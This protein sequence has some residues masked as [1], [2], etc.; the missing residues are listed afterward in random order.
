M[1]SKIRVITEEFT[2]GLNRRSFLKR[3][4]AVLFGAVS[5]IALGAPW[6][7]SVAYAISCDNYSVYNY[8]NFIAGYCSGCSGSTCPGGTP[9]NCG[10]WANGC[11]CTQTS[12]QLGNTVYF[13]C[14]D[15]KVGTACCGCAQ[16]V[17]VYPGCPLAPAA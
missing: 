11:W 7:K 3:G 4:A 10:G 8:C 14:C 6:T 5:G 12:C 15:C 2:R 9:S 16:R 1:D 17:L 13:E